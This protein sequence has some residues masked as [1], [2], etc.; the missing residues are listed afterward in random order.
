MEIRPSSRKRK[1]GREVVGGF[2]KSEKLVR[3]L[4]KTT[5]DP[6]SGKKV[7]IC[8]IP[9]Q[10]FLTKRNYFMDDFPV[11]IRNQHLKLISGE[12]SKQMGNKNSEII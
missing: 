1:R 4:N 2:E 11:S 10:K 3:N 9:K 12:K 7:L 5:K 6:A 8:V